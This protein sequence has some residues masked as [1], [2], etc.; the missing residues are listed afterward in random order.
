[1]SLNILKKIFPR[2]RKASR[3]SRNIIIHHYCPHTYNAGD[4]FVILSIRYHLRRYLPDAVF[5]PKAIAENRGWGAPVGL[6][7]RNIEFSNRYADAVILGGSDQYNDWSP[8][9]SGKEIRALVPPLFLIG[10]GVSSKDLDQPPFL[11]DES[12]K[13]DIVATNKKSVLSSVRDE[14]TRNFLLTLGVTHAINTGCPALFLFNEEFRLRR[15]R[16]VALTFPYPLTHNDEKKFHILIST[17]RNIIKFL[18]DTNLRPV[19]V[20]HDDRDVTYAQST[21]PE[22]N[23]FYSNYPEDYLRF[24]DTVLMVIGS[25][26]HASILASG[27]GIPNVN[28]NLDLRGEG[29]AQDMGMGDWHVNYNRPN[30]TETIISRI[31]KVSAGDLQVFEDLRGTINK[32]FQVFDQFMKEA[33]SHI[34]GRR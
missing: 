25:R 31:E 24:Y 4:H 1:M 28:I 13:A 34:Q 6:R 30:L 3:S 27:M 14:V 16:D 10:L 18:H 20:C 22:E 32:K 9:I 23:I 33:V 19:I 15:S 12:L 26:L 17:M 11:S 21:F 8:R 5:I 7:G 2:D 29:F